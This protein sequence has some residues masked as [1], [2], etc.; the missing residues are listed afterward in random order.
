L[1]ILG[2]VAF[3]NATRKHADIITALATWHAVVSRAQ[4]SSFVDAKADF[5]SA[6]YVRP[7]TVFNIRG[8]NYRLVTR[9]DYAERVVLIEAVFTHAEY[10]KGRWR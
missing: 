3:Q 8:G 10:A 1:Q 2:E 7:F 5:S 4:W 6:D 9:I